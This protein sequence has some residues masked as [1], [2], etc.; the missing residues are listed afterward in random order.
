MQQRRLEARRR[1]FSL[2]LGIVMSTGGSF[3]G[4]QA[5]AP[6][7]DPAASPPATR[8]AELEVRLRKLEVMNQRILQQYEAMERRHNERYEKLSQDF[9]ALQDRV[10]SDSTSNRGGGGLNGTV[11]SGGGAAPSSGAPERVGSG[12]PGDEEPMGPQG[13]IGRGPGD[14][15]TAGAAAAARPRPTEPIGSQ[16]MRGPQGTI[17]RTRES[18]E[19]RGIKTTVGRGLRF[20]SDD[21][22]FQLIFHDLTQAELRI[23]PNNPDT[24]P[25]KV[26]FDWQHSVFGQRVF[27][28]PGLFHKTADL[29]WLRF[30]LFF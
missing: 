11:T 2:L 29:I 8:E 19:D 30:Q 24:S 22:E 20:T 12:T 18:G 21:D 13:T 6:A 26:Y 14:E 23:F 28:G 17:S 16:S 10:K 5:P 25:L 15:W 27:N 3:A 9:R 7:V 4:A 1:S